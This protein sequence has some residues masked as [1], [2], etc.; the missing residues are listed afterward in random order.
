MGCTGNKTSS[1]IPLTELAQQIEKLQRAA[2]IPGVAIAVIEDGQVAYSFG[3]G[4]DGEDQITADTPFEV[5]SLSKPV[6]AYAVLQLCEQGALNL[7]SPISSYLPT[8]Y[9]A[10]EPYLSL[11]TVRHALS[12]TSGFPNW[13][14]ET[15]LRAA[16]QPGSKF[17]Y[18]TE[19]LV[20]LQTALEHVIQQPFH[21]YV[22]AHIL[23]PYGMANSAFMRADMSNAP[24]YL[25]RHLYSFGAVS[26]VTT[27]ADY[28]RFLCQIMPNNVNSP[29]RLSESSLAEMMT[30]QLQV[31]RQEGLYWGLGW[32]IEHAAE[33]RNSF[34]H[35]GA[36]GNQTRNFA[37]GSRETGTG[38]VILTNHVDGLTI[39]PSIVE[40]V[41]GYSARPAFNWLLP[42]ETWRAD[43][44]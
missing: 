5:A 10:D 6:F 40:Q 38:V 3:A 1:M 20:Y 2:T 14:E 33:G 12:H 37:I 35:W 26:L 41:M 43:G 15:G 17:H 19:G 36:R 28:A 44:N 7:D 13:R 16:F 34:W 9:I 22:H 39:C 30:P 18:S 27:A 31:G 4:Y 11:I 29:S 42:V 23:E 8:P 24:G 25:P 21:A 32:G